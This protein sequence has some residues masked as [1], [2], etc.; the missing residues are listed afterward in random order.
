MSHLKSLNLPL[1]KMIVQVY[2]GT[3][4]T[5]GKE[6]GVQAIVKESCPLTVYVHCSSHELNSVLVK[7][8]AIPEI[9]RTFIGDIASLFKSSSKRNARLTTAIKSLSDRISN[10]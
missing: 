5:S 3:S 4:S 8:F 7:S 2:D 9:H 6:K 10:K 1:E